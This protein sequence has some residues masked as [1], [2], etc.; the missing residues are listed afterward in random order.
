MKTLKLNPLA[1]PFL[2]G[3]VVLFFIF[4]FE[5]CARKITFL[6]S[7]V[8][9]AAKGKVKVKKNKH[10][11]DNYDTSINIE[12]LA[13]SSRLQPPKKTY[14]LWMNSAENG[15]K[16][17]GEINSS[18][19]FMSSALKASFHTVSV[20]KP[21]KIFITAEDDANLQRPVGELVLT[22]GNF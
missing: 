3:I 20:F 21:V 9:P 5:F 1:G 6:S 19:G 8:V 16:N 22:T 15:T 11:N 4:S 13:E 2:T 10:G 17:I 7:S 18:T 12:H 14:V